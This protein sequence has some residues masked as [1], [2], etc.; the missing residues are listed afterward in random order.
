M[1]R[2][3]ILLALFGVLAL[4]QCAVADTMV[5]NYASS[6]GS[7]VSFTDVSGGVDFAFPPNGAGA[8]DFLISSIAGFPSDTLS[9]KFG[10]ITG[11]YHYN[12]ADIVT[13][14]GV[15]TATVSGAGTF[16]IHDGAGFDFTASL[17]WIDI[18]TLGAGGTINS[19]GTV[20]LSGFSYGGTNADL[21]LL[22]GAPGGIVV[23]T[24]Q[25]IPGKSLTDLASGCSTSPC[26]TSFSGSL[27]TIPEP[28][29]YAI[30]AF[31]IVG[32]IIK[33]RPRRTAA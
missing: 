26:T 24:F 18:Q 29:F 19:T 6:T 11:T 22:A 3:Y 28:S 16:I 30:L 7:T 8:S 1:K 23:A 31:G 17:T 27:T 14:G 15:Q 2:S 5:I 32:A 21:L 25:F 4:A 13:N 20:N 9:G 12:T 33:A 10:D